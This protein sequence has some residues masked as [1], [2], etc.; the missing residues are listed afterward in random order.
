M[1]EHLNTPVLKPVHQ[2]SSD[3]EKKSSGQKT[4][5][6]KLSTISK[7]MKNLY[8]SICDYIESLGDDIVANQLKLYLAYKKYK[9]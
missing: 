8:L 1:F 2:D 6:E 4:H 3:E 5:M 9:T 7:N